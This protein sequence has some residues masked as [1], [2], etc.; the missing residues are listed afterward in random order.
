MAN[1]SIKL[2]LDKE[3]NDFLRKAE[4]PQQHFEKALDEL[5][6]WIRGRRKYAGANP[7]NNYILKHFDSSAQTVYGYARH[8]M[9][10]AKLRQSKPPLVQSGKLLREVLKFRKKVKKNEAVLTVDRPI[11][12][13]IHQRG[14]VINIPE[15]KPKRASVLRFHDKAMRV[16]FARKVRAHTVRIP[17][18]DYFRPSARD[19]RWMSKAFD[20]IIQKI[21]VG[22]KTGG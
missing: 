21:F 4:K 12:A 13:G 1:I 20:E 3:M 2:T 16:V 6:E 5:V 15:I 9:P 11:Y 22:K 18:R 17:K 8:K 19:D 10:W 7:G 14:G